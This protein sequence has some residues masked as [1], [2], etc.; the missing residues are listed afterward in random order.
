METIMI[1]ETDAAIMDV[2]VTALRMKGYRVCSL[3][4]D[5]DNVLDMIARY[6]P[7][8][9]LLDC[10]LSNR[11]A[12]QVSQWIKAHFPRLPVIAFSG[13]NQIGEKYRQFGFDDFIKKPFDAKML[14]KV[15]KKYLPGPKKLRRIAE[16]A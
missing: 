2:L 1:Q 10:W 4:D 3:T 14:Y 12:G 11:S 5:N 16:P 9:V 13:D 8:I 15:V 6:H 7:K